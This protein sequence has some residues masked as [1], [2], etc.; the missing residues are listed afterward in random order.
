MYFICFNFISGKKD[1][2]AEAI[3]AEYKFE[4]VQTVRFA[5]FVGEKDDETASFGSFES[6]LAKIVKSKGWKLNGTI[7]NETGETNLK[8]E[9]SAEEVADNKDKIQIHLRGHKLAKKAK[10]VLFLKYLE[11]WWFGK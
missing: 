3:V 8:I 10:L 2:N 11:F 1:L 5:L 7:L 4:E 9:L 6:T